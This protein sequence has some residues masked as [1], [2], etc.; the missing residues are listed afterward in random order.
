MKIDEFYRPFLGVVPTQINAVGADSISA[1]FCALTR[2]G[3]RGRRPLQ[4]SSDP[5]RAVGGD[6][7]GAPI[8]FHP[9][10]IN[11]V[12]EGLSDRQL[13]MCSATT[14]SDL[15][16]ARPPSPQGEGLMGCCETVGGDVLGAP[17][18]FRSPLLDCFFTKMTKKSA[19]HAFGW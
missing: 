4:F 8:G 7:L 11:I 15:A 9:T 12:G 2:S 5:L 1:R 14:S 3:R 18:C 13:R 16:D 6:V 10:K 17:F 19:F